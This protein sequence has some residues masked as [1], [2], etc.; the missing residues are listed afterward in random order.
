MTGAT[1]Y[2]AIVLAGGL[3][4]R[5]GGVDKTALEVGGTPILE[6]VTDGLTAADAVA[7]VGPE[8]R[9]GPCAALAAGLARTHAPVVL[10]LAGDQPFVAGAV[11]T[12][13]AALGGHDVAVLTAEGHVQ[14]LAAAWRRTAL[15]TALETT[16]ARRGDLVGT[17][18][19]AL[20][21]AVDVVEVAD[22][23]GWSRDVDTAADLEEVRRS[24]ARRERC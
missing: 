9:G 10:T 1:R 11:P 8:V 12:L 13:L 5:L 24:L 15:A 2:D 4:T 6:R 22:D 17:P 14:L 20:F 7:V 3:A 19:R 16:R 23:V 18:V 21:E